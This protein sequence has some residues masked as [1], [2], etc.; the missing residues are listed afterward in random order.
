MELEPVTMKACGAHGL[1]SRP[2]A[3]RPSTAGQVEGVCGQSR[4]PRE[5]TALCL[6]RLP[7]DSTRPASPCRQPLSSVSAG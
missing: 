2:A 1:Y 6:S 3:W 4:A 7:A 5:T